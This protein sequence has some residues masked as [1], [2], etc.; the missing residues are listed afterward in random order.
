MNNR[1]S[2]NL[3]PYLNRFSSPVIF[4]LVIT[5]VFALSTSMAAFFAVKGHSEE[6]ADQLYS[7]TQTHA[8]S[9]LGIYELAGLPGLI[10]ELR[11]LDST[12]QDAS[13]L[14]SFWSRDEASALGTLA[15]NSPFEGREELIA[16]KDLNMGF[17]PSDESDGVYFGYG[18]EIPQGWIVV[19]KDSRWISDSQELLVESILWG[20]GIAML[21]VMAVVYAIAK[22]TQSRV[23]QINTVLSR[24]ANGDLSARCSVAKQDQDELASVSRGINET[25][26]KLQISVESL[27][28][29]SSDIAHDLRRPLTRLRLKLENALASTTGATEEALLISLADV[30][31]LSATF[32]SILKLAQI[33]SGSQEIS[34]K[35]IDL[36]E[37]NQEIFELFEAVCEDSGHRLSIKQSSGLIHA[38]G[39]INLIRQA[40]INLIDNAQ[41]YT[42]AGTEITIEVGTDSSVPFIRV[43]DSGPGISE[44]ER[45]L[46]LR[47]FYRTDKSRN[48]E[49]TGLGLSLVAAIAARH[50]AEFVLSDN[51]PGL[52]A[53]LRFNYK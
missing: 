9:Y 42:P 3:G 39:D 37:L 38:S 7:D 44:T 47:R 40:V 24:A 49:G 20:L 48:I 18:I 6:L 51:K 11:K 17:E 13:T 30:D 16:S 10:E 32:D 28:Q 19:A 1:I 35:P 27:Q 36:N 31:A 2:R 25:L 45:E 22:A 43:C 23:N 4:A 52:C 5:S 12:E 26:E 34:L 15:L 29:V 33:E 53:K 8:E 21:A 41:R 50:G 46:V 14:V